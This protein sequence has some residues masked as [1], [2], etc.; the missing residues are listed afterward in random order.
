MQVATEHAD[1]V[2]IVDV[3]FD[4]VAPPGMLAWEA[5]APITTIAG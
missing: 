1:E 4:D 2:E 5:G 3:T